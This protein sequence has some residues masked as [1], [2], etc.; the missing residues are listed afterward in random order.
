MNQNDKML[1]IELLKDEVKSQPLEQMKLYGYANS[2]RG[3]SNRSLSVSLPKN[4][5]F[6]RT[7]PGRASSTIHMLISTG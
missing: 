2:L 1:V 3:A 6:S 7:L 5:N 4:V